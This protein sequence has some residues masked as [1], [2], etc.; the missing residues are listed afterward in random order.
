MPSQ[1]GLVTNIRLAE[2]SRLVSK[3][4]ASY[5][6]A[7]DGCLLCEATPSTQ[8]IL[9]DSWHIYLHFVDQQSHRFFD[10][11]CA[12]TIRDRSYPHAAAFNEFITAEVLILRHAVH[13]HHTVL[14]F[15]NFLRVRG[16]R[17]FH[18]S[19]TFMIFMADAHSP[20]QGQACGTLT[21]IHMR[22]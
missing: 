9:D 1:D 13:A 18:L 19:R 7:A 4:A 11:T 15:T 22:P 6:V 12:H 5:R 20:Y 14:Q 10:M 17:I 3:V 8:S 2:Y 16:G 21:M